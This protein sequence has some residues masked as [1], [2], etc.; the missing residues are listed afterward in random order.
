MGIC[1]SFVFFRGNYSPLAAI[2]FLHHQVFFKCEPAKKTRPQNYDYKRGYYFFSIYIDLQK[3]TKKRVTFFT[4]LT[5]DPK[6][7]AKGEHD[8]KKFFCSLLVYVFS[9]HWYWF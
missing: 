9:I 5:F 3:C 4:C 1:C 6:P 2:F 8:Q 7:R